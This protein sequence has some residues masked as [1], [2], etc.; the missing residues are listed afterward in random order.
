MSSLLKLPPELVFAITAYLELN[1]ATNLLSTNATLYSLSRAKDF[2]LKALDRMR[3]VHRQLMPSPPGVVLPDLEEPTLR[4]YAARAFS[5][6]RNWSSA[7]PKP[8]SV[9]TI[10]FNENIDSTIACAIPGT[11]LLVLTTDHKS[12]QCRDTS[13]DTGAV[14]ASLQLVDAADTD[15]AY[16]IGRSPPLHRHQQTLFAFAGSMSG[17][18]RGAA[19]VALDYRLAPWGEWEA[20]LTLAHTFSTDVLPDPGMTPA[21]FP[22]AAVSV[23][24]AC[25]VYHRIITRLP[26][27]FYWP[28]DGSSAAPE[29]VELS[30]RL[31]LG[32]TVMAY[33]GA[34]Y[35][36]GVDNPALICVRPPANTI[37]HILPPIDVASPRATIRT[38]NPIT[39]LFLPTAAGI[40]QIALTPGGALSFCPSP[41]GVQLS[42]PAMYAPP[43]GHPGTRITRIWPSTTGRSAVILCCAPTGMMGSLH[44]RLELVRYHEDEPTLSVHALSLNSALS[45]PSNTVHMRPLPIELVVDDTRGVLYVAQR[46]REGMLVVEYA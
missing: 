27:L 34:F 13:S 35:V 15:T 29:I 2:W 4:S 17:R 7:R 11:P 8:V 18:R 38:P 44:W 3:T 31:G 26:V 46:G 16:R 24:Y 6:H 9:R 45:L 21:G 14:L 23:N 12:V 20:A 28:L 1:D 22:D 37:T 25:I 5:L 40:A 43:S 32:P 30:T 36:S 19:V 42:Q 41:T 33:D 39:R 10:P